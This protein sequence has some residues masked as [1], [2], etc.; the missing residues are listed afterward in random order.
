MFRESASD[1]GVSSPLGYVLNLA[2]AGVVLA[3]VGT[4]GMAFFDANSAAATE[5]D[6]R[7]FGNDLAGDIQEADRLARTGGLASERTALPER[8][9]GERY[10]IEV[11][12]RSDAGTGGT[13]LEHATVCERQCLVL[14]TA[15]EAVQVVVNVVTERR[16]ESGRLDGGS[17]TTGYREG[18]LAVEP[19]EGR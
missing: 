2:L 1:R 9:R 11:V 4:M 3:G 16:L 7:A 6:L 18:S 8:V 17:V 14:S 10:D 19:L 12:N 13:G 15:D 5:G